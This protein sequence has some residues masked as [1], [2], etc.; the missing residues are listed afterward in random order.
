MKCRN[1]PD[2]SSR[3]QPL[4]GGESVRQEHKVA[5]GVTPMLRKQRWMN[6]GLRSA[7]VFHTHNS[8]VQPGNP[9][10]LSDRAF[11]YLKYNQDNSPQ[12]FLKA[13]PDSGIQDF[14]QLTVSTTHHRANKLRIY[15]HLR[16]RIWDWSCIGKIKLKQHG[17]FPVNTLLLTSLSSF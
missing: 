14:V 15:L 4:M 12:A 10:T 1:I 13:H 2:H 17:H 5:S 3:V 7:P 8:G 6:V 16:E 9:V 11:P